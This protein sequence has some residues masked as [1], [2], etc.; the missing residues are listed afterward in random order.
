MYEREI[1][2]DIIAREINNQNCD[3][4]ADANHSDDDLRAFNYLTSGIVDVA[5][6]NLRIIENKTEPG[7]LH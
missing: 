6:I 2:R 5:F 3:L 7:E 1:K 4:F